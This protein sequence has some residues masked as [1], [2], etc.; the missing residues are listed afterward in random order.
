MYLFLNT[1]LSGSTNFQRKRFVLLVY[2]YFWE[3]GKILRK[4]NS[5]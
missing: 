4:K 5:H 3:T 2:E 1:L